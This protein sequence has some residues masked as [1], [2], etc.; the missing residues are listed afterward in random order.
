MSIED[1]HRGPRGRAPGAAW[2]TRLVDAIVPAAAVVA[3]LAASP[4]LGQQ[5]ADDS[6][7]ASVAELKRAYLRCSRAA[8]DGELDRAGI[9]QCSVVYEM[10]KHRA[11]DGDFDKLYAWS[12]RYP[13]EERASR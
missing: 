10:L 7:Q 4:A 9:M 3:A 2:R 1:Q 13:V 12:R 11:F 5:E 6:T 8:I